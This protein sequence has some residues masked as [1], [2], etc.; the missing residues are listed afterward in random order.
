VG[1]GEGG[2]AD[3][4][5]SLWEAESATPQNR[6]DSARLASIGGKFKNL[7]ILTFEWGW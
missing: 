2:E 3:S 4:P 6:V 7:K 5:V 1:E